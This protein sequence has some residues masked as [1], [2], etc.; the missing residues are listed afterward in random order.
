MIIKNILVILGCLVLFLGTSQSLVAQE[1]STKSI[2]V[3]PEENLVNGAF[4][5]IK[6]EE[7]VGSI[8]QL[9]A[10]QI[11][12]YDNTIWMSNAIA[13]RTTG[14]IG[15]NTIRGIGIGIDVGD[16]TGSG[17]FSGNALFIVDGLP[18]DI[19]GLRLSEVES[20]TVLKDVNAAILYGSAAVNGVVLIS[21][22]RGKVNATTSNVTLNYGLSSPRSFPKYLN[23]ADYMTYFNQAR[24]NDGLSPQFT[25]ETIQNYRT[26]NKYRYPSMDYYSSEYLRNFKNYHD[27]NAEFSGGDGNAKFYTNV[28]WNST[29][30]LLSVGQG[31]SARNNVFNVR[32]NVDLRVNNR[33]KTSIDAVAL[34]GSNMQPRGDYWGRS[35]SLRPNEYSPLLPISLIDPEIPLLA[36]RKNEID[37]SYLIGGNS[38]NLTTPLGDLNAAGSIQTIYRKFTFNNRIDFSLGDVTP[39]LS[40]HTNISFDY[41]TGYLQTVAN[42]Y[43]VY[44]PTWADNEDRIIGLQQHGRDTRTGTQAVS[45]G[46][47]RR[48]LGFFGQLAYDRHF[49]EKHHVTGNL[50]GFGSIFKENGDFQGV[51]NTHI[52]VQA[53]YTFD[54][55]YS[56]DFSGA[57]INSV[58]LSSNNR[59]NFAPSM[60]VSWILNKESFL[61]SVSQINHLKLRVSGG[62]LKTDLPIGGFF[63][64]DN[65]YSTSGSYNWYEGTRSRSG[66]ISNSG[67]NDQLGFAT[68]KEIN[69]GLD[70]LFFNKTLGLEANVFH[71]IYDGLVVRPSTA[72]P[73]FYSDFISYQNFESDKY[74]G[75]ELGLTFNKTA[76]DWQFFAGLNFLYVTSTRTKVDEVYDNAYQNRQGRPKDATFGLESIGF[77]KDQADIDN[78]PI[79]NFGTVR[80]GDLKYKDQNGDGIVNTNDEVYLRRWQPPFSGGLQFRVAYKNVSLYLLGEGRMGAKNFREGNYHWVDGNK[81]YSEVVLDAWTPETAETA[82]YPRLSSQTN[83]NNFR[84]SSFWLYS[85]DYFQL[86]RAQV[87][88][89]VPENMSK[90]LLMSGVNVFINASDLFQLAKNKDL[91]DLRAGS[92][93]LYRTF[94]LGLRANF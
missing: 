91:R 59:R 72:F 80:P 61:S 74:K 60:G 35:L 20:I 18:R 62:I 31:K 36:S 85:D 83:S 22:K 67:S 70:G 30:N 53:A 71:N 12:K 42:E 28:G 82:T 55:R 25:D 94:T 17:L 48:R 27:V 26:G 84:R 56:V 41:L 90:K 64:Y 34:Y 47:F 77:F 46:I 40:A 29:G 14:M 49:N 11:N 86:R 38:S 33:I 6:P 65:R 15:N 51:K 76:G 92:E 45:Q 63:Y 87:T 8:T 21:T 54:N 1:D 32:G 39:G 9:N 57:Y 79:Q 3:N 44:T 89:D 10:S 37:G 2:Q 81:K 7:L 50:I 5:K 73:S 69:L 24:V 4:R 75:A 16:I 19:E 93:P 13:G 23:S 68:R 43:S 88:Y 78:S 52:G 66:V 58:K